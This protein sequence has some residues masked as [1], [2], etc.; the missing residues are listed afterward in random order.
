MKG[1]SGVA[2]VSTPWNDCYRSPPG[3]NESGRTKVRFGAAR[4]SQ[5]TAEMGAVPPLTLVSE[6]PL[7]GPLARR[8]SD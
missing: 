4:Q 3:A 6:C 8:P 2:L 5:V 7:V 1:C